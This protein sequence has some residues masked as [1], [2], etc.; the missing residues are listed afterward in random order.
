MPGRAGGG[1]T[2][3]VVLAVLLVVAIGALATVFFT[4]LIRIGK[5]GISR[6]TTSERVEG[7][8]ARPEGKTNRFSG[9]EARIYCCGRARG[10]ED[11]VFGALWYRGGDL[12]GRFSRKFSNLTGTSTGRFLV[13]GSDVAF[14]L[15]RPKGGWATGGYTVKIT[16]GGREAAKASFTISSETAGEKTPETAVYREPSGLFSIRYPADWLAADR[17]SLEGA[18]AGFVAP[19][20]GFP[21]RFAVLITDFKSAS[22]DYLNDIFRSAG[23]HAGNLF[24][25]YSLGKES[26]A[27]RIYEW[28]YGT[29][30]SKVKLKSVQVV[31]QGKGRVFGINCHGLAPDFEGNLPIFNSII[32]S[33]RF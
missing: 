29:G 3:A 14:Y 8:T 16:V 1:G 33:F 13:T 17:A 30:Q 25:K 5:P 9:R 21:P 20:T 11:T 6:V 10:F 24:T 31:V 18:V 32:N 12:V 26:G 23:S 15:A 27:R 28:E 4:G 19:G 22:P 2:A 7:G